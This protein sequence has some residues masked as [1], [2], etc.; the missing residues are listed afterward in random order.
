VL[1]CL[2][3]AVTAQNKEVTTIEGLSK[4]EE[5]HP[6]QSAFIE[7][8][9]FQCGFCTPGQIMSSVACIEEGHTHNDDEI[10]EWMS[11][12]LCRCSA[13]PNILDAIKKAAG[14]VKV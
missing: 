12:N 3:L 7:C 2:T 14:Q 1:S 6:L 11:G 8:D 9:G 10:R 5:L 13:Y 4:G